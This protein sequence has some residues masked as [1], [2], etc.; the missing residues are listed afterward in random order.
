MPTLSTLPAGEVFPK[1]TEASLLTQ[2]SPE[3]TFTVSNASVELIIHNARTAE[4][5]PK[6][7][8]PD[9]P[10]PV[11][12]A[13]AVKRFELQKIVKA[14]DIRA[15]GTIAAGYGMGITPFLR[16]YRQTMQQFA[17]LLDLASQQSGKTKAGRDEAT[18][19]LMEAIALS[20]EYPFV[21]TQTNI[22]ALAT[23]LG[24][25]EVAQV[26]IQMWRKA[27]KVSHRFNFRKHG[28][29]A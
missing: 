16:F 8:N 19:L 14:D 11:T 23:A 28:F 17:G 3:N 10:L 1:K 9:D 15:L 6:P 27:M 25:S 5:V 13:Y 24:K 22:I 4:F 29:R 20:Q 7:Y 21:A 12:I 18:L 26:R 2:P